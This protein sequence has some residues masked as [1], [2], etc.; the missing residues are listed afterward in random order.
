ML[1]WMGIQYVSEGGTPLLKIHLYSYIIIFSVCLFSLKEGVNTQLLRLNGFMTPWLIS[2]GLVLFVILYGLARYGTSGMAYIVDT[3]LSPLLFLLI[4]TRLNLEECQRLVTF[5]ATLLLINSCTA[6]IE[7]VLNARVVVVEFDSFSFFRSTAFLT[8]PLNNA[9]ITAG[10]ALLLFNRTFLPSII[11]IAITIIALFAFGGRAATGILI[12]FMLLATIPYIGFAIT[13]GVGI[14]PRRFA[15]SLCLAYISII[16]TTIIISESGIAERILSKLY[17]DESASARVDVLYLLEQLTF[18]EWLFGASSNLQGA[19]EM[20]LGISVIE[21]F[22]IG[23]IFKFGLIGAIPLLFVTTAL[24]LTFVFNIRNLALYAAPVFFLTSI[25][26][27][28]LT[29]KTPTLLFML[30][31]L[32]LLTVINKNKHIESSS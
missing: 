7:F 11:Y 3:F 12:L 26:N 9:L 29:T 18:S 32:Y 30:T 4:L 16:A 15:L 31:V 24:I 20:Y 2:F 21:N 10:L 5:I 13:R 1:E 6:I 27:N 22:F 17:V 23:W 28:S 25:T 8:H 14:V 19:I